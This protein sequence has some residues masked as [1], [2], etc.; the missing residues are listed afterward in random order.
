[1]RQEDLKVLGQAVEALQEA[2]E[3][4]LVGLLEQENLCANH[5][6]MCYNHAEG[7][8]V[9]QMNQ[10]GYLMGSI[11]NSYSLHNKLSVLPLW[12]NKVVFV[13]LCLI[14]HI[15]YNNCHEDMREK[16]GRMSQSE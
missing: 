1:M 16:G 2:G 10:G 15:S 8:T 4:F 13:V 9:G 11:Y 6:K 3:T 7:H 12:H 5:A 14:Q